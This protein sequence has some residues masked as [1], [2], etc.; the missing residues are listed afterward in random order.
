MP[1][2]I[3]SHTL[4]DETLK[5]LLEQAHQ[6]ARL[7]QSN[8]PF[9]EKPLE[10][11]TICTLFY[12]ASTRTRLSFEMAAMNLGARV[13]PFPVEQ[14]SL[15][16]GESLLDTVETLIA[17]GVDA[18]VLRHPQDGIHLEL[19]A[20]TQGR[21]A[22]LNAGDGMSDHPTQGLLDVLT[23]YQQ[24]NASF[25]AL[26]QLRLGIV[27]DLIH[28]RV[29][30]ATLTLAK[31]LGVEIILYAPD[32]LAPS[33]ETL[34]YWKNDLGV[35]DSPQALDLNAVLASVDVVM[36]LRLQKERLSESESAEDLE[37]LVQSVQI[38]AFHL[39]AFPQLKL[40]HPGPVNWGVE[41]EEAIQGHPQSLISQQVANGVAV[42]MACLLWAL[43]K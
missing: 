25:E 17:L 6:F 34:T 37:A 31:Q 28:S 23:L 42:R 15:N 30:K 33:P 24:A 11:K 2:L 20:H 36:A 16:K 35:K 27:G 39:A 10:G 29:V 43:D 5:W 1:S 19:D 26:K 22:I 4:E 12:E 21:I 18:L 40:M 41:L 32:A 8:T 13:L 38:K 7:Q 3:R 14:S 9:V